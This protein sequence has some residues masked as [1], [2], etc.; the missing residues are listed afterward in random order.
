[1]QLVAEVKHFEQ[2][3]SHCEQVPCW[4]KC[5]SRQTEQVLVASEQYLQLLS[6]QGLQKLVESSMKVLSGQESS[7]QS[8]PGELWYFPEL[9]N[10]HKAA[11]QLSH[12]FP[13]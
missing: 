10:V 5:P 1:M 9:H 7:G 8:L 11:V 12:P 4:E 13:H 6:A 3:E 2:L